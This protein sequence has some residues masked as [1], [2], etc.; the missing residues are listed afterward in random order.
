MRGLGNSRVGVRFWGGP[1]SMGGKRGDE[2]ADRG[3]A[4]QHLLTCISSGLSKDVIPTSSTLGITYEWA[5]VMCER[6]TISGT[7][8]VR[9]R[10]V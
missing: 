8:V 3:R 4:S 6:V 10:E 9:R 1:E 2:E 7:R 5:K